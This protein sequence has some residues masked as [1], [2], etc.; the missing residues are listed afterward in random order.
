VRLAVDQ[1][2]L[3]TIGLFVLQFV[4]IASVWDKDPKSVVM[5]ETGL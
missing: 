1:V 4:M 3:L 2:F 5:P